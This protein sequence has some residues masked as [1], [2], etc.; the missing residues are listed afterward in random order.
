MES[1]KR[2]ARSWPARSVLIFKI[3]M[4]FGVILLARSRLCRRS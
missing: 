3:A 1:E 2:K 4:A